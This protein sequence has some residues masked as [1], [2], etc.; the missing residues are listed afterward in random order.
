MARR[1][2]PAG[3]GRRVGAAGLR[4]RDA[5]VAAGLGLRLGAAAA[6]HLGVD[7]DVGMPVVSDAMPLL[8][9]VLAIGLVSPWYCLTLLSIGAAHDVWTW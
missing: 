2:A 3:L 7:G 8:L 4:R 9:L 6:G 5:P 1:H